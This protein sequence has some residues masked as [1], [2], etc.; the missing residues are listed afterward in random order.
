[1]N[2]PIQL[3]RTSSAPLQDQLFDQL[4]QMI[5]AGGL[6]LGS[7]VIATRFLAEQ[8]GVSRTTVLQAYERLISEGYLETTPGVG[9]FVC[10]VLPESTEGEEPLNPPKDVMRQIDL[11]PPVQRMAGL[12]EADAVSCRINFRSFHADPALLP[13]EIWSR[14]GQQILYHHC[15]GLADHPPPS[16]VEPLR[17]AIADW[18]AARRG[19]TVAPEQVI[20]VAGRQ[21]A[22]HI[23]ASLLIRRGDN[24]IV[25]TPGQSAVNSLFESMGAIVVPV[26]VDEYGIRDDQLPGGSAALAYVTPS[27]QRPIGGTLP[28]PRRK[29]LIEWARQAGAYIIEDDCDGKFRYEGIAPPPLAALDPYGLVFHIGTFSKTLGAGLCLGYL[30]VPPEFVAPVITAKAMFS[31]GC[32]WLDQMIL[33]DFITSGEYEHHLRRMRKSYMAR[34]DCLIQL[35][36]DHFGAVQLIGFETGT[37]LTW[38]LPPGTPPAQAIRKIA[39]SHG[40]GLHALDEYH[41][42]DPYYDRTLILGYSTLNEQQLREGVAVLSDILRHH[43]LP[44]WPAPA[45]A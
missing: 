35:L 14:R 39:L 36:R 18:F 24:V 2:L 15:A 26:P 11:R 7:R 20:I 9:T 1:M 25:E 17:S 43:L 33:A 3:D 44:S 29:R 30:I 32:S 22:R 31:K 6:K 23:V 19:I 40:I 5:I 4:R 12:A 37:Q 45:T 16:G 21:Q 13:S 41:A 34:R 8:A 28:L 27:R 38:L 10:A 42:E